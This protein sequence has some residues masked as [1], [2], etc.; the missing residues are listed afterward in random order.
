[1]KIFKR[2][3]LDNIEIKSESAFIDAEIIIN[4]K[5]KKFKIKRYPVTHK[6]R[7]HGIAGGAKFNVILDTIKDLIKFRLGTP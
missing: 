5:R 1:M 3:V 2:K 6:P 7:V 4:T